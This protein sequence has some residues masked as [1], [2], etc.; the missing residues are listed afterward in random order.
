MESI[1][2]WY[3]LPIAFILDMILGDP[4]FFP[5]PIRL[6]GKAIE[7]FEPCFRNLSVSLTTSGLFYSLSLILGTWLVTFFFLKIMF[8]LHP[9]AYAVMEIVL[10]YYCISSRCL[11]KAAMDV[12]SALK[13]DGLD[14]AKKKLAFIVGRDIDGLT[15]EGVSR[16]AVE[17]VAE[18]LVDGVI[19]P[20]F[21]AAIGGAPLAM[22]FKM[23]NTLDSMVGYK[24][25]TYMEF[26]KAS[27]RIDDAAN[28][29]PARLS[30]P[31]IAMATQ[32]ICG[33]GL[34]SFVTAIKEGKN[35]NSPN[36]GYSEAAFAGA[37]GVKLGGPSNYRGC[38]V[39][40]PY[41][42]TQFGKVKI[43]DIK[44]ACDLMIV[45][46]FLWLIILWIL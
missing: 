32:M 4:H 26:G 40:K 43:R 6:M 10:I 8:L 29:I 38:L 19:S 5:H 24:N 12:G 14:S 34:S 35:H 22:A 36:A 18:N 7:K 21:Y 25:D 42:G 16:A 1:F 13:K 9:A 23:I 45:S 28:Y 30:V 31:V 41:I 39:L 37:L 20:L 44:R 3:T 33:K 11:Q 2:F 27:A 46:S 17:T 15:Q